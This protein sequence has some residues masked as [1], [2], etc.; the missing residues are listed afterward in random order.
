MMMHTIDILL[1]KVHGIRV[2]EANLAYTGSLT[3]DESIMEA[4]GMLPFQKVLIVNNDNGE[5][6]ETYLIKG[7]KDSGVCCLNGAAAHKGRQGDRLILMVFAYLDSYVAKSFIP[8][9]VFV[10]EK[11]EIEKIEKN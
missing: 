10:N 8:V 6:I 9:R 7:E 1:A 4:A 3:L 11:N 5:R 2:T